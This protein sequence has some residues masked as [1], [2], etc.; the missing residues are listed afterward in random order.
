MGSHKSVEIQRVQLSSIDPP[1]WDGL[2]EKLYESREVCDRFRGRYTYQGCQPEKVR[3]SQDGWEQIKRIIVER[4]LCVEV[5]NCCFGFTCGLV[6]YDDRIEPF[7]GASDGPFPIFRV[8]SH[9]LPGDDRSGFKEGWAEFEPLFTSDANIAK[10]KW[11]KLAMPKAA[12]HY[13]Y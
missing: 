6:V 3:L 5:I 2:M 8:C 10:L 4:N 13:D 11:N 12:H 1:D 9:M 7:P